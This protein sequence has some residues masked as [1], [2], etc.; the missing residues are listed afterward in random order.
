MGPET[1][2]R[3]LRAGGVAVA[4]RL[5]KPVPVVG[6][7]LTVGL[8]GYEM[9]RKGALGG[10]VDVGLDLLPVVGTAK[11]VLEIF[12]GDLIPDKKK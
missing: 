2:R 3:V 12:T 6:A 7:A 9:K 11:A 10:A 5:I 1:K 4:R 8:A